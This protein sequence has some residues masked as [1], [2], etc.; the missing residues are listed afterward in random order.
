ML[1]EGAE[2][3]L[4]P[5]DRAAARP[6]HGASSTPLLSRRTA[7]RHD[8]AA[9]AGGAP[10]H[11]NARSRCCE[12]FA[13]QA[14]IAIEN[15]R[16]FNETKE[17]LDQQRASGEV[18]RRSAARSPTRRRCSTRSSRAASG[19]SPARSSAINLVGDDGLIRLGALPRP[20]PGR[21]SSTIFPLPVDDDSAIGTR[22]PD[23]P[24]RALSRRRARRGRARTRTPRHAQAIG[25]RGR[26]SS[27]RCCGRARA[28]ARSASAATTSGPFSDKEIALLKTFADQAVI[29][30]QNARLFR[31]IQDKSRAARDREQ[32]QVGVPRQHVA[33]AA[34]AAQRDH[35]LFRGAAGAAVRR[36]QRE[37]G[38]LPQG[39]PLV[40]QAPARR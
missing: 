22:D 19:C 38:R 12:T 17:A 26:R 25:H 5:R 6:P 15:V 39:H 28:S 32:A 31:E 34:H 13:D 2:Y 30:I 16:L 11:A 14:V 27:R 33:R 36:A 24:R 35:R 18:L 10:V 21:D 23:A 29:A 3:P 9:A 37:A 1:A 20:G 4:E 40:R 8:P 7:V